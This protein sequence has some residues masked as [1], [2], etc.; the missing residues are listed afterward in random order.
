MEV[1][2]FSEPLANAREED[3][4]DEFEVIEEE[5]EGGQ[6]LQGLAMKEC[7]FVKKPKNHDL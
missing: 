2:S 6:L 3:I 1:D 4:L 7:L 5:L